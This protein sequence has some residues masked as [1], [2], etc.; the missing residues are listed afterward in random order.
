MSVK[1][2][3]PSE[4]YEGLKKQFSALKTILICKEK[5]VSIYYRRI[6]EFDFERIIQLEA[7]LE[8]EKEMNSILTEEISNKHLPKRLSNEAYHKAKSLRYEDFVSWWDIQA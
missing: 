5:E 2:S 4:N 8:S 3:V 1:N 7:N 6:K